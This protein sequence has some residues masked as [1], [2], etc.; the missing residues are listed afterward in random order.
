MMGLLSLWLRLW[1]KWE[2][3]RVIR[4]LQMLVL[5][6]VLTAMVMLIVIGIAQSLYLIVEFVGRYF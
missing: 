6:M 3:F 2:D 1:A 4:S 5:G